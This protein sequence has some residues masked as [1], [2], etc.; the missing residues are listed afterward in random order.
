MRTAIAYVTDAYGYELVRHSAVSVMLTQ[1]ARHDVHVFCNGFLPAADDMLRTAA[2]RAG[3]RLRFNPIDDIDPG[4]IRFGGHITRTCLLKLD[5]IDALCD[6]YDR[7]LYLDGDVLVFRD[8]ALDQIAMDGH[9]IAA[10]HDIAECGG[11][12]DPAFHANCARTGRSPNYFNAGVM[13]VDCRDWR[14]VPGL[15]NR[16]HALLRAHAEA[17]DYKAACTTSEQCAFNILFERNWKRL[18]VTFNLQSC[19]MF[20]ERWDAAAVRHYVGSRKFLPARPWRTDARDRAMLNR[21]RAELGLPSVGRPGFAAAYA[22]NRL[23]NRAMVRSVTAALAEIEVM[24]SRCD[25]PPPVPLAADAPSRR[26]LAGAA[27]EG[28][29][30]G[31]AG[32]WETV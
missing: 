24:A 2:E 30:C 6:S 28:A 23:R 22:L 29:C 5:A 27:A 32:D 12:T 1:G 11:I 20:S 16:Y 17:C 4:A 10:V 14:A 25:V 19:A 9:P 26:P 3:V 31:P 8:L 7:V 15:R 18:P 13:V 21:V